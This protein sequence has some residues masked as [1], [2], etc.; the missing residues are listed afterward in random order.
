MAAMH[1]YAQLIFERSVSLVP[2]RYVSLLMGL[3][4]LCCALGSGY[5]VERLGRRP[6]V[7]ASSCLCTGCM[8]LMGLHFYRGA[9]AAGALPLICIIVFALSYGIGLATIPT[10]VAA[11]CL[12]MDAR[13]IGAAAQNT[14]VCLS[15][16]LVTK[17]WQV[18][19]F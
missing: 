19:C 5:L 4:E 17:I 14:A 9:D 15:I 6:L 12:S 2:G 16:F 7:A 1:S 3:I 18:S 10:V 11:E 13:N 8:A